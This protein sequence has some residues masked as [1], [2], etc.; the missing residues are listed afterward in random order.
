MSTAAI[1]TVLPLYNK[2]G[3]VKDFMKQLD[4]KVPPN[5]FLYVKLWWVNTLALR[6]VSSSETLHVSIKIPN[7]EGTQFY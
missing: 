3:L 1:R 4:R 7:N 2:L 6:Y 5:V